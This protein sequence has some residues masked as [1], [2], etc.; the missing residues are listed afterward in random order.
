[1]LLFILACFRN[2]ISS[3]EMDA[4]FILLAYFNI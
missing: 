4:M 2:E 1:M 3:L